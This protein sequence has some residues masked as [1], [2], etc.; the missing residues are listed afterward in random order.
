M[1]YSHC[2]SPEFY[3]AEGEPYDRSDNAVNSKG[4]P[5]SLWSALNMLKEN[6]PEKWKWICLDCFPAIKW[7]LV[8]LES[9]FET[10]KNTDTCGT[11]SSP[12][13]VW[14]DPLGYYTVNVYDE[15]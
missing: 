15:R 12:V 2:F 13:D 4:Q 6:E 14:I 10:A 11:L 9:I 5:V 7:E 3:F 8:A 1:A